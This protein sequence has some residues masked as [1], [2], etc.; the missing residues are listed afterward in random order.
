MRAANLRACRGFCF[1]GRRK[2]GRSL[3]GPQ[4]RPVGAPSQ[5]P[6][7]FRGGDGGDKIL[8]VVMTLLPH[9]VIRLCMDEAPRNIFNPGMGSRGCAR[10]VPFPRVR[11]F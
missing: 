1:G 6:R 8:G 10:D 4:L 5:D 7:E 9:L 2:E 11:N 3:L